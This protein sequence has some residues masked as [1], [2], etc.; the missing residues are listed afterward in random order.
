MVSAGS[1]PGPERFTS[2]S[3]MVYPS[4]LP[5]LVPAKGWHGRELARIDDGSDVIMQLT[6]RTLLTSLTLTALSGA[7]ALTLT[8]CGRD[9]G[10]VPSASSSSAGSLAAAV[11]GNIKGAGASSQAD[12]QDAWMNLFLARNPDAGVEYAAEGSGAGREK[13][14]AGAVDFAASDS[15]MSAEELGQAGDVVE[16]PLYISPI[17][18]A[19]NLPSLPAG[20]HVNM[21]A[22]VLARVLSGFITSWDDPALAALNP[23]LSLPSLPIVVVH[24][25]D[26]SG[27][28]KN[29]T[30]YLHAAA[31]QAW[32]W[33]AGES[34]PI[35]GGQ[36]GDGTSGMV[37]TIASAEGAIGYA[38]ASKVD[39]TLGTVAIGTTDADGQQVFVPYSAQAAAATLDA[40]ALSKDADDTHLVYDIRYDAPGTYPV[41]LVSY[42]IAPRVLPDEE[43]AATV[44]AYLAL[45]A[46]EEGQEAAAQAAG[47]APISQ[48]LREQVM[49][50][51]ET[52]SA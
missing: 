9:A 29:L 32:T 21:T 37:A 25:S 12:A 43:L 44:R 8:A 52:V 48:A 39:E 27:T 14:L 40:S 10:P 6:L 19:Y 2:Q 26:E 18:L 17:A 31:P 42:L 1:P 20:S 34:W 33:E 11:T 24:R 16:V 23:D 3:G 4:F 35:E 45:A 51:I 22:Q 28:T 49:A 5:W 30:R 41:I 46:S 36:S 47:S 13:L 7:G 38:D 50:A 15:A